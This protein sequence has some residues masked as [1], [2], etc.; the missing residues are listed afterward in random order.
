MNIG[1]K[2]IFLLTMLIVAMQAY[3]E[4]MAFTKLNRPE[5]VS[6]GAIMCMMEDH[7]GYLWIGTP[8]GLCHY[9]G[10]EMK[11]VDEQRMATLHNGK[12]TVTKLQEDVRHNLWVETYAGYQ[13]YDSYRSWKDPEEALNNLGLTIPET[14]Y[15][16]HVSREGNLCIITDDSLL[17]YNYEREIALSIDLPDHESLKPHICDIQAFGDCLLLLAGQRLWT[18]NITYGTWTYENLPDLGLPSAGEEEV[19]MLQSKCYVDSHDGIWIFTLF[20]EK[21]I[22]HSNGQNGWEEL[23]LP[24]T[25]KHEGKTLT[26]R[27]NAIREIKETEDGTFWIA[28]NHRGLFRYTPYTKQCEWIRQQNSES[29]IKT[30]NC[31][32]ADSHGTIWLGYYK[33]GIDYLPKENSTKHYAIECGDVTVLQALDDGKLWI[34]TDGN[35]LWLEN[36]DQRKLTQIL[37]DLTIT[38]LEY[39]NSDGSLWVGTYDQGLFHIDNRLKTTHLS[40]Q[41]G[42]LPHDFVQRLSVDRLGQVWICSNFGNSYCYNPATGQYRILGNEQ[43]PNVSG[44]SLLYDTDRDMMLLGTYYGIWQE[45]IGKKDGKLVTGARD[46]SMPLSEAQILCMM[47]DK[48]NKLLWLGHR[49]GL[50]IWDI[51][52]DTLYDIGKNEGLSNN[53]IQTIQIDASDNVWVSMMNGIALV[54]AKREND[55]TLSFSVRSFSGQSNLETIAYNTNASTINPEGQLIFGT[56]EGY[57]SYDVR[58]LLNMKTSAPTPQI[59]SLV[60]ADKNYMGARN[61]ELEADEQPL[62]VNFYTGNPLDAGLIRYSYCIEGLQDMW[63]VTTENRVTLLSL[64][65]GDYRL[66]VRASLL[67]GEWSQAE[68]LNIHVNPPFWRSS[69][70]ITIYVIL[71][72]LLGIANAML[73]RLYQK[74]K[75]KRMQKEIRQEHLAQLAEA[76]LQFFTNVSHDLRTPLTLILSPLEQLLHEPLTDKA[77][78]QVEM[79]RRNANELLTQITALLDFRKLDVG[80][81]KLRL[82][83]SQDVCTFIRQQCEAFHD[84]ALGRNIKFEII[85][86]NE[87]ISLCFDE[88]KLRRIVYNLLSNAFKYSPDDGVVQLIIKTC[89]EGLRIEV[90]DQGPGIDDSEK[91]RIFERFYQSATEDPKPGNGVGLHI[92]SQYVKMNGGKIWV[93]DN[94]PHGARFCIELPVNATDEVKQDNTTETIHNEQD[95]TRNADNRYTILMVDDNSDLRKFIAESLEDSY[96]VLTAAD[97]LEALQTLQQENVDLVVSDVMMPRMNGL[98]LCNRIKKNIEWSHIPV[99]LLT[100]KTADQSMIEGLQHGADDYLT[101][102]FSVEHLLL[103]IEKFIEWSNRSHKQFEQQLQDTPMAEIT[104]SAIDTE[105]MDH[106]VALIEKHLDNADFGVDQLSAELCMSRSNLYKKMMAV[107]GKSPIEFMRAIR[108]SHACKLLSKHNMQVSEVAYSVGYNSQKRFTENFKQEYGITPTEYARTHGN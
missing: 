2:S 33:S 10:Y 27:Q 65:S 78:R 66:M 98:E 62:T 35:G 56:T 44:V 70:M 69:T 54:N 73:A 18:L 43:I 102:P 100:A 93:E 37:Q 108:M 26:R 16:L 80:A 87:S 101:K 82:S 30:L 48:R 94:Q 74:R 91:Q 86:G 76:K 34:G 47:E 92:A 40:A 106:A 55:N 39:D 105:L 4:E 61:L 3:A 71:A 9:D 57:V 11:Q 68:T 17:Y 83:P 95:T 19:S 22:H 63:T 103:R 104:R 7:L 15:K 75:E 96:R 49:Q 25:N 97:G 12:L 23:A 107:T 84:L 28:T 6:G 8:N 38:D 99:L 20:G 1:K 51:V 89:E 72:I 58:S 88:D 46:D 13:L 85:D 41:D 36:I 45:H 5:L 31:L 50:T 42:R 29:N 21:I 79:V 32:L 14:E 81:E 60:S 24:Q 52:T 53:Q 67:N 64:P 59:I 77:R 90:A